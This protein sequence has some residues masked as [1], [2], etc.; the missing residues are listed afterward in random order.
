M[1]DIC[2]KDLDTKGFVHIQGFLTAEQL[3]ACRSDYA[4]L[5]TG[6]KNGNFNVPGAGDGISRLSDAVRDVVT[7]IAANTTVRVDTFI[8]AAYFATKRGIRFNW[9]QD[10][11]SYFLFQTHVNYLNLYI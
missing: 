2:W 3:D 9:H 5:P 10:H 8:G 6:S 4:S 1:H 7:A 11:E